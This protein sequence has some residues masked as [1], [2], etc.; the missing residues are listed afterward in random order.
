MDLQT[1]ADIQKLYSAFA[2]AVTEFTDTVLAERVDMNAVLKQK[3]QLLQAMQDQL[4]EVT[5]AH[6]EFD[7]A[8]EREIAE[9]QQA[10][11]T[12]Q[13]ELDTGATDLQRLTRLARK[14]GAA[15]KAKTAIKGGRRR[16]KRT[17]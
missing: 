12:L 5:T 3:R 11:D 9:R 17:K 15:T 7:R 13:S 8:Y 1:P 10:I 16:T 14:A 6:N 4:D 2:D